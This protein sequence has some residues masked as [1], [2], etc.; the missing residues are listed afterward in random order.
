MLAVSAGCGY[1]LAG[2]GNALPA[3]IRTIGIP[4]L[5]NES[6]YPD[7]DRVLTSMLRAEF[8]G[9][10]RYV[11][12][13]QAAGV[14]GWVLVPGRD[15]DLRF[16]QVLRHRVRGF[17]DPAFALPAPETFTLA[18]LEREPDRCAGRLLGTLYEHFG[19]ERDQVPYLDPASGLFRF[20]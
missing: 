20:P 5:I 9:K 13:P 4:D 7:I 14:E 10:G 19:H 18:A 3:D 2:R 6:T 11:V 15:D 12:Q 17:P 16:W 1:A 8:Q